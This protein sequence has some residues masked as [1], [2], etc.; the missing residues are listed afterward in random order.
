LGDRTYV[1]VTLQG[2]VKGAQSEIAERLCWYPVSGLKSLVFGRH[3]MELSGS[4][5]RESL[6][7]KVLRRR[8]CPDS[9]KTGNQGTP[10]WVLHDT[11]ASTR[12]FC[13]N[14]E[15]MRTSIPPQYDR[16]LCLSRPIMR[17]RTNRSY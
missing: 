16:R 5:S 14:G 2:T 11:Q 7:G 4:P 17:P 9:P 1:I 6:A 3:A 15:S 8:P 13:I 10:Y 12:T